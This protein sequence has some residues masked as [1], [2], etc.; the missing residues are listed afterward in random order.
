MQRISKSLNTEYI[1]NL[2]YEPPAPL[3]FNFNFVEQLTAHLPSKLDRCNVGFKTT[4]EAGFEDAKETFV[5]DMK[6]MKV[7]L[8]CIEWSVRYKK[9]N[10]AEAM[11]FLEF[12]VKQGQ[13][14]WFSKILIVVT[15]ADTSQKKLTNSDK[16]STL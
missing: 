7:V 10:I 4:L 14:D 15:K 8:F 11:E 13:H 16:Q 2:S 3:P 6:D 9:T 5:K 1:E 12:L